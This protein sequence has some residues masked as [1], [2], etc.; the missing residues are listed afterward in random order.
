ME[1]I[2]YRKTTKNKPL[3]KMTTLGGGDVASF[4]SDDSYCGEIAI[5]YHGPV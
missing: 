5:S 3:K 1:I 2:F 4:Q